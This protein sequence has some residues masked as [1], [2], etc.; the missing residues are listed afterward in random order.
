MKIEDRGSRIENRWMRWRPILG[1]LFLVPGCILGP[2]NPAATQPATAIDGRQA[3]PEYWLDQPAV[4][5]ISSAD[6]Y[7]LWDACKTEVRLRLFLIDRQD[8]RQGLLTTEPLDSKQFFE[9]WRDDVV[10]AGDTAISSLATVR[11]T[12]RFQLRRGN[13]GRYV[14]EPKVLVERFASAERRI[15]AINQYHTVFTGPATEDSLTDQ[16]LTIPTDYWYPI[17]RDQAL[18]RD[19]ADSIRH[20]LDG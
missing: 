13:D 4:A 9:V 1:F 12:V 7:K 20:R 10:T 3:T 6:F 2:S 5:D 16:G 11:R 18:E 15:I 8:Y 19:L 17:G 14:A